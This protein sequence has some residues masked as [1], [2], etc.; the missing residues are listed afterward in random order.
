MKAL[1]E[2]RDYRFYH[3]VMLRICVHFIYETPLLP[4]HSLDSLIY[5]FATSSRVIV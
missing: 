4:Y 2:I 3:Y 1:G 5:T